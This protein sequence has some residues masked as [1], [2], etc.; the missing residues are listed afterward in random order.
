MSEMIGFVLGDRHRERVVQVL[1]SRG[2]MSAEKMAKIERIP[3]QGVKRV[4]QDLAEKD[5]VAEGGGSWG[6][7]Q[8]GEEAAKEIRRKG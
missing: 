7:T 4:L 2:A 8:K 1:I 3:L 5:I 6:L